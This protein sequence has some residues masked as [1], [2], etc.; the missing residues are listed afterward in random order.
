MKRVV[1]P[2]WLDEARGTAA[3]ISVALSDLRH[4]N[5]WFGGVAATESMLLD[6]ARR[7]G[8]KRLCLLE[9]ASGGGYVP[10]AARERLKRHGIALTLTL[11]DRVHSHLVNGSNNGTCAIA[12]D[13]RALPFSENSF[14]LVNSCL[15]AHH[16]E[17]DELVEFVNEG[18]R[19]CRR[20]VLIND[21]VR[22]WLHLAAAYLT[23]PFYRSRF[24]HHDA[25]ASVRRA[26]LMEEMSEILRKTRA[27]RVEIRQHP[28][29]RMG[30]IAWKHSI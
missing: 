5:Q 6:V 22:S 12:A 17:P 24:T 11:L 21:L 20:A 10:N 18:L 15:F 29:F 4:I 19:V 1:I 28:M 2:E 25:P 8:T 30:V 14:D 23:L 27:A 26:Y 3:E 7:L 16:L 9:V 13:A